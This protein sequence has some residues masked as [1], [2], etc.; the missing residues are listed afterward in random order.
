[1]RKDEHTVTDIGVAR[2]RNGKGH[3]AKTT[4]RPTTADEAAGTPPASRSAR[5]RHQTTNRR[6]RRGRTVRPAVAAPAAENGAS[7]PAP[8]SRMSQ[9]P[10]LNPTATAGVL[11]EQPERRERK[12]D[13]ETTFGCY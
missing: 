8:A 2:A 13:G 5:R 4:N 7:Q 12:R 6:K 9:K 1:M 10:I 11:A 3:A